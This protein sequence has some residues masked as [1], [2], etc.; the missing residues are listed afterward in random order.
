[1]RRSSSNE[2]LVVCSPP[3]VT[4]ATQT[5]RIL[6]LLINCSMFT[7]SPSLPLDRSHTEQINK[8]NTEEYSERGS[9]R[10]VA[11]VEGMYLTT[12]PVMKQIM[13]ETWQHRNYGRV[14]PDTFST[15]GCYTTL[16]HSGIIDDRPNK[17]QSGK[18]TNIFPLRAKS[19]ALAYTTRARAST[20]ILLFLSPA[21]NASVDTLM[22][23]RSECA[24]H[25]VR[26]RHVRYESYQKRD[27]KVPSMPLYLPLDW[28]YTR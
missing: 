20:A 4:Y 17:Q 8:Y 14:R 19:T 11:R 27:L 21:L 9:I 22:P 3:Y 12:S 15:S 24:A 10:T 5:T 25:F 23:A 13:A 16:I 6:L 1:M 18:I 28:K 26:V 2:S 7:S